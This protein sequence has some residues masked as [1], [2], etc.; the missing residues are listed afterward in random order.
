[1][2][3]VWIG[4]GLIASVLTLGVVFFGAPYVPTRKRDL[5]KL[6]TVAKLKQGDMLVD[7]GSGDGRLL[8]G[9]AMRGVRS[10]GIE[11][12]PILVLI[13]WIRLRRVRSL[14]SVRYG[15]FWSYRLPDET[16]H[17]FVFLADPFMAR[18][19]TYLESESKRLGRPLTLVS[20]GFALPGYEPA[21]TQDAVMVFKIKG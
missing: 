4:I 20:Y 19:K 7:L 5:D 11:L 1:M 2:T 13:T 12:N 16:T 8:L 3:D 18:L 10:V 21:R 6:F 15:N 17:V 14:A 9:A